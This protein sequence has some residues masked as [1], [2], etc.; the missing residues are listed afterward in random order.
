MR[1]NLLS[2]L[3]PPPLVH[4]WDF[5]HD[6]QNRQER[7]KDASKD[8]KPSEAEGFA[9]ESELS[10]AA[11]EG[12]ESHKY[13]DRLVHLA[14]V[15]DVRAFWNLFN[16][17]DIST[18]PLRDSVHLFHRGVKP[19]W[20]DARNARG[21]AWTFRVPKEKAQEFWKQICMLAIG[22]RLQAA[23]ESERKT[24]R[25]DICG[26]SLSVR[27]TSTLIQIWN[28]DARHEEGIAMILSTVLE[29]ISPEL[30]PKENSYYYKPHDEH[31][32][33]NTNAA[34]SGE[35]SP[36]ENRDMSPPPGTSHGPQ[37]YRMDTGEAAS[38]PIEVQGMQDQTN[39]EQSGRTLPTFPRSTK[40]VG[41]MS[42]RPGQ[43]LDESK[44]AEIVSRVAPPGLK[45]EQS[46]VGDGGDP[47]AAVAKGTGYYGQDEAVKDIEESLTSMKEAMDKIAE[48]DHH[49]Q[50]IEGQEVDEKMTDG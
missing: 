7:R 33:F 34:P 19:V 31:A 10:A 23:V 32:G 11:R 30:K 44:T 13:E 6:R 16:N 17:F 37:T 18:L 21:G 9:N 22:E 29:N 43:G 36:Q 5:W 28:R 24:F 45:G 27:F 40:G 12:L 1:A 47:L 39:K 25:D 4:S 46:G 14:E 26:V 50:G 2:K 3:R 42:T 38:R 8:S 20:E 41:L 15:T 35:F 48:K 49:I